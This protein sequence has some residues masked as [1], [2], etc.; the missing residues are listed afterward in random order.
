VTYAKDDAS[1][2]PVPGSVA[3]L[4]AGNIQDAGITL[5]DLVYVPRARVS[6]DQFLRRHDIL[7]AT[8][9]G[10]LDVVGKAARVADDLGMAFGAFCKVLR[11]RPDINPRYLAHYFRTAQYRRTIS[12]L[13]AGVNINNLR[14]EHLDQL[15]VPVPGDEDQRRIAD[16]LDKADAIRRK[17]TEVI[18]LTEELIRSA[19]LDLVGPGAAGYNKWRVRTVESLAANTPN[20]MRTGPFGSD[21]LHSEFVDEGIAVLGIDNAVQNRFAWAE[22][23]FISREKY[24]R[25]RRYTVLPHDVIVTIMGTTGRSAVV[26]EDIPTAITTKHLATITLDRQQAEPE[27]VSQALFRHPEVLHQVAAANRGAIMSG[28]NLG[29]IK[30]LRI[31]VPP[32]EAQQEFTRVTAR[33]RALAARIEQGRHEET[34]FNSLIARAFCGQRGTAEARC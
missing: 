13:A 25:L 33:V 30:A 1:S 9:S 16:I 15:L 21:L 3:V 23:R 8:S 20:S 31:P 32:L 29:L 34:L 4:R 12:K 14:N 6:P 24:E 22:R 5:D 17:R 27:F 2:V 18:A 11:P 19:F 28:L 26:P 7:I 10:S